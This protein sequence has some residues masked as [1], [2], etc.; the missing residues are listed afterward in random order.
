[1]TE[2]PETPE[3]RKAD[4]LKRLSEAEV[5][6][7]RIKASGQALS[8]SARLQLDIVASVRESVSATPAEAATPEEWDAQRERWRTLNEFGAKIEPVPQN[9]ASSYEASSLSALSIASYFQAI[10][11]PRRHHFPAQSQTRFVAGV[12]RFDEMLARDHRRQ[13][14][15]S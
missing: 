8:R 6:A 2:T 5:Q 10:V 9:F 14:V 12:E 11:T 7:R 1:V 3:V 13:K 4:L 15:R